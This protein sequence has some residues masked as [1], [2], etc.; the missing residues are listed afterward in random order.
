M[1]NAKSEA[2]GLRRPVVSHPRFHGLVVALP[3]AG[4]DLRVEGGAAAG[5]GVLHGLVRVAE[6]GDDARDPDRRCR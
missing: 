5:A 3:Q 2:A 1:Q 6:D 4:E